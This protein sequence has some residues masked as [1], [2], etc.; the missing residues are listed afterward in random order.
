MR[1][2]LPGG[3]AHPTT[4][5]VRHD[6]SQLRT[7]SPAGVLTLT[8][9]GGLARGG[10]PNPTNFGRPTHFRCTPS[11]ESR[12][13]DDCFRGIVE[14]K[15]AVRCCEFG[16]TSRRFAAVA[17]RA[18]GCDAQPRKRCH[19]SS[20]SLLTLSL[21]VSNSGTSLAAISPLVSR[22]A[23]TNMRRESLIRSGDPYS[24]LSGTSS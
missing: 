16:A 17:S 6:G 13:E 23:I 8:K 14:E 12:G 21:R 1:W 3:V 15:E 11:M 9:A 18:S 24:P 7:K 5:R 4:R 19:P 22:M 10:T 20:Q 2:W